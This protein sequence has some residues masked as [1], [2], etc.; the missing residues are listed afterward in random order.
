[1]YGYV[2]C[3]AD[4]LIGRLTSAEAKS[5]RARRSGTR[6]A[7]TFPREVETARADLF[8]ASLCSIACALSSRFAVSFSLVLFLSQ[9]RSH[10]PSVK[11]TLAFLIPPQLIPYLARYIGICRISSFRVYTRCR[12]GQSAARSFEDPLAFVYAL[13]TTRY[14]VDFLVQV[15]VR[16]GSLRCTCLLYVCI[17]I[18]V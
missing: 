6:L 14:L 4:R 16:E 12:R 7:A 1:M 11:F 18:C 5:L 13:Y 3:S 9:S 2:T 8:G 17:Y 15:A 10:S